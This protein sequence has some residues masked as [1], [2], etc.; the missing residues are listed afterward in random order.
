MID[1]KFLELINEAQAVERVIQSYEHKIAEHNKELSK[2]RRKV[3]SLL[4]KGEWY[5]SDVNFG[6]ER[7]KRYKVDKVE[8]RE[9]DF[10][11]IVKE[12]S[13][14]KHWSGHIWEHSYKLDAFLKLTIY[15]TEQEALAVFHNRV[16]PKCG[17]RMWE[18]MEPWC[19]RCME[20]RKVAK[21]EYNRTHVF[22]SPSDRNVYTVEYVDEL[23]RLLENLGYE[24]RWFTIRR[25]DTGEVIH[26]N[27]LWSHGGLSRNID[28]LPEIEFL[29]DD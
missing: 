25:L 24:G 14:R 20:K 28:N 2:L 9:G 3:K 1:E 26:T 4:P 27:N 22:Y 29:S 8:F 19:K 18:S 10:Y 15:D 11:V 5:S 23:T 6:W 17:N 13:K 7:P 16:C 21:E 12:L